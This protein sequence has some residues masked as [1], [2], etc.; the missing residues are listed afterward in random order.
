MIDIQKAKFI[1][2]SYVNQFDLTDERIKLK[3]LHSYKV[4]TIAKE[5][6]LDIGLSEKDVCLAE[7]IGLFHDIGRFEQVKRYQTFLDSK[8][9]DHAELGVSILQEEI[10]YLL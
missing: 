4:S 6:A 8:S 5:I 1:F 9:V 3:V 2:S 7:I 10:C